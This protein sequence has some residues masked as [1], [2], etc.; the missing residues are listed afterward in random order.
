[1]QNKYSNINQDGRAIYKDPWIGQSKQFIS[2]DGDWKDVH[3]FICLEP[4]K[5]RGYKFITGNL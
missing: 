2:G 3:V 5:D 1:M 4:W